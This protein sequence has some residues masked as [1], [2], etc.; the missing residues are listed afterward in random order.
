MVYDLKERATKLIAENLGDVAAKAYKN[1]YADKPDD[2]ILQSIEE[3]LTEVLGESK[4][5]EKM[6]TLHE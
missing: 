4:S 6:K 2:L 5:K 1:F 3:L